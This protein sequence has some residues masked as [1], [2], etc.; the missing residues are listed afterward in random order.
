M[1]WALKSR[2]AGGVIMSQTVILTT[3]SVLWVGRTGRTGGTGYITLPGTSVANK[4]VDADADYT[5]DLNFSQGAGYQPVL[6]GP[7]YIFAFYSILGA[8][9][10]P[11]VQF[12]ANPT[13]KAGSGPIICN[14]VFVEIG[15]G[16]SS[17]GPLP[18]RVDIDAFDVSLG[19]FS[20]RS[21][22]SVSPDGALDQQANQDGTVPTDNTEN[23]KANQ[24]LIQL[25]HHS[26]PPR[27]LP[28]NNPVFIEWD[29]VYGTE[30]T[31]NDTLVAQQ[32]TYAIAF[33]LYKLPC[34]A[35]VTANPNP[36]S[37]DG[38]AQTTDVNGSPLTLNVATAQ[39]YCPWNLSLTNLDPS[40][41]AQFVSLSSAS[42]VGNAA[43]TYTL[44]ANLTGV[45]RSVRASVSLNS[46]VTIE[47]APLVC[48][49]SIDV[50]STFTVPGVNGTC[51]ITVT[52]SPEC[53]WTAAVQ[54]SGKPIGLHVTSLAGSS[55]SLT[56]KG[57]G[58]VTF[59]LSATGEATDP[60]TPPVHVA[61][62]IIAG[63]TVM[64][65]QSPHPPVKKV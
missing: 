9:D 26:G 1:V 19:V 46:Y 35:T 62:L 36:V 52:T 5:S 2:K 39:Q 7:T 63:Y 58:Y 43:V 20:N 51:T 60:K 25:P 64:V 13:I 22:V 14:L 6:M 48:Q 40:D 37:Y 50:P 56:G 33:A 21:F 61:T 65:Y 15:D 10:G 8:S 28:A 47:Q 57:N 31:N 34:F 30:Q 42:G 16:S 24:L 53:S 59:G 3:T 54:W 38:H 44:A 49:Y 27:I 17:D 45:T 32:K 4:W 11:Q 18:N 12:S 23:V 29:V 55:P 41:T